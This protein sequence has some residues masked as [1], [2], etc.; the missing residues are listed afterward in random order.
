VTERST[1]AACFGLHFAQDDGLAIRYSQI[2]LL[3]IITVGFTVFTE[4]STQNL[5]LAGA[6][7]R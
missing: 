1:A 6:F 3:S 7:G 2:V 4:K 5:A